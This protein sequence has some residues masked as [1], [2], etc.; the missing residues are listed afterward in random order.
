MDFSYDVSII[1][2]VLHPDRE[3]LKE[4]ILSAKRLVEKNHQRVELLLGNDGSPADEWHIFDECAA[5]APEMVKLFHFPHNRGI[6]RTRNALIKRSRGRYIMPFDGDDILL[7]FNLDKEIAFLDE[8]PEYGASYAVKYLFNKNGLTGMLHGAPL[9]DFQSYFSPKVNINAML[10]RRE[11]VDLCRGFIPLPESRVDD[12]VYLIFRLARYSKLYFSAEARAF[13]R[14][15]PSS[16]CNSYGTP[17]KDYVFMSRAL[18]QPDIDLL[19]QWL[20]RKIPVVPPERRHIS[21]SVCGAAMF[22]YQKDQK[23]AYWILKTATEVFPE[24]YGA[25]ENFLYFGCHL[26]KP[27][28][29]LERLMQACRRFDGDV[30]RQLP[31]LNNLH[32]L[33]K[34]NI[35]LPGELTGLY[36]QCYSKWYAIP[37]S[38]KKYAP[39]A[40]VKPRPTYSFTMPKIKF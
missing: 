40:T 6:G 21:A 8:N 37:E 27:E 36:N 12:D 10:I 15:H 1:V 5:L 20:A 19:R 38:V 32:I 25:W 18:V 17:Q 29:A 3:Y 14:I 7:V 22:L 34:R 23:F 24:D 26:W 39:P 31:I 28:E 35:A 33:R 13:Y 16:I 4:V 2:S 9:S 11:I 30:S